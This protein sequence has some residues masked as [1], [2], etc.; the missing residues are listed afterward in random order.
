MVNVEP[1]MPQWID[2]EAHLYEDPHYVSVAPLL[3]TPTSA[4]LSSDCSLSSPRASK[5][6]ISSLR[7]LSNFITLEFESEN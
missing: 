1:V 6:P 7:S 4:R 3:S 2:T 5:S